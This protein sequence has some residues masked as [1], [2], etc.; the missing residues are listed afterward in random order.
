MATWAEPLKYNP[1]KRNEWTPENRPFTDPTLQD[2]LILTD[3]GRLGLL[4]SSSASILPWADL[5]ISTP[6]VIRLNIL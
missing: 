6:G 1:A 5:D 3:M 4:W 2:A